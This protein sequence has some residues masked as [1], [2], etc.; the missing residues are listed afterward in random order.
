MNGY[1]N[2]LDIFTR[3]QVSSLDS[4]LNIVTGQHNKPAV[5]TLQFVYQYPFGQ[6]NFDACNVY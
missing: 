4:G 6:A 1:L 2:D 3:L 5:V